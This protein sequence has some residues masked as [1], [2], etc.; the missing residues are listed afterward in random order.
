LTITFRGQ[1]RH[2]FSA[3]IINLLSQIQNCII[4]TSMDS[5]SVADACNSLTRVYDTAMDWSGEQIDED[6]DVCIAC[7][8][9]CE[10]CHALLSTLKGL[11][12]H[13]MDNDESDSSREDS[14][15]VHSLCYTVFESRIFMC[16]FRKHTLNMRDIST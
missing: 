8:G 10:V 16:E 1:T 14:E 6:E 11:L 3:P 12:A 15:S 4:P 13:G 5:T 7:E 9:T 2:G